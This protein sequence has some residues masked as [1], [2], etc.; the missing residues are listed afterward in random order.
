MLWLVIILL[1]GGGGGLYQLRHWIKISYGIS[2]NL[3]L[4]SLQGHHKAPDVVTIRGN[5][6]PAVLMPVLQTDF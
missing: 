4:P 1:G 3:R 2:G 5:V 6:L